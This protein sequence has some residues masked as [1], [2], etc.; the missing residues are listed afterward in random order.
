MFVS[1]AEGGSQ[2]PTGTVT[3]PPPTIPVDQGGR[4]I[5]PRTAAEAGEPGGRDPQLAGRL[6]IHQRARPQMV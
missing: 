1:K 2:T 3:G 5:P 6:L 4:P